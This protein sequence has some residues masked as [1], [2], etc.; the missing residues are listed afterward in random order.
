MAGTH[1]IAIKTDPEMVELLE[2]VIVQEAERGRES[3]WREATKIIAFRIKK[4][5]GLR[6]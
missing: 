2:K 4:A 5:G 3:S 6:E 1:S